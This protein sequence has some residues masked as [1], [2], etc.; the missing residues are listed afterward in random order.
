MAWRDAHA[1]QSYPRW[2]GCPCAIRL[3]RVVFP[4]PKTNSSTDLSS[5]F[6]SPTSPMDREITVEERPERLLE[7]F[8]GYRAPAVARWVSRAST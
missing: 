1:T 2:S 5:C 8:E 6:S 7:R 4:P 3:L